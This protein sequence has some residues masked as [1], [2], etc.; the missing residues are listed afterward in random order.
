MKTFKIENTNNSGEDVV[1]M[2][3]N[4]FNEW[5]EMMSDSYGDGWGDDYSITVIKE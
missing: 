3:E 5:S 1:I 2:T 4:E